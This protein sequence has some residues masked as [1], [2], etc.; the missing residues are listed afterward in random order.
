MT[1]GE[2]WG[3]VGKS[4]GAGRCDE[5]AQYSEWML[6]I[7]SRTKVRRVGR[8]EE[9]WEGLRDQ[10]AWYSEWVLTIASRAQVQSVRK[11]GV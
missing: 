7:V 11:C 10:G 8:G 4:V 5:G 1:C 3:N 6:A 9:V 2:G